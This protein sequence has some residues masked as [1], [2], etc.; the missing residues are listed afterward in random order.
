MFFIFIKY[1]YRKNNM[2]LTYFIKYRQDILHYLNGYINNEYPPKESILSIFKPRKTIDDENKEKVFKKLYDW[3][4]SLISEVSPTDYKGCFVDKFYF[5]KYPICWFRSFCI[6]LFVD[7]SFRSILLQQKL[8]QT[9]Q[10]NKSKKQLLHNFIYKV[11]SFFNNG[12]EKY[13]DHNKYHNLE[14]IHR[15]SGM[16]ELWLF[17]I[18]LLHYYNSELFAVDRIV[19]GLGHVYASKFFEKVFPQL[20]PNVQSLQIT[21]PANKEIIVN[22]PINEYK[23]EPQFITALYYGSFTVN[24]KSTLAFYIKYNNCVYTLSSLIE[25]SK[26]DITTVLKGAHQFGIY[27]CGNRFYYWEG[28]DFRVEDVDLLEHLVLKKSLP[29]K[30]FDYMNFDL[31]NTIRFGMYTKCFFPFNLE[32]VTLLRELE[33][34]ST[35]RL[36]AILS[37]FTN[38]LSFTLV[39]KRNGNQV[40]PLNTFKIWNEIVTENI[41]RK[42]IYYAQMNDSSIIKI[43]EQ[44][45][46][47][48][49]PVKSIDIINEWFKNVPDYIQ[50]TKNILISDFQASF[51]PHQTTLYNIFKLCNRYNGKPLMYLGFG[52]KKQTIKMK[53]TKRVYKVKQNK[54]KQKYVMINRQRVYLKDIKGCYVW[55]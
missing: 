37:Y 49:N 34:A 20:Y 47:I 48:Y 8:Q 15:L 38:K 53:K 35:K 13:K 30:V 54:D 32:E 26:I 40:A 55:V 29:R 51:Y 24:P 17:F 16:E 28:K 1:L 6:I 41:E 46:D 31:H 52:G 19:G 23:L 50:D 18:Y 10:E 4:I 2:D 7:E 9:V 3:Y 12:I 25:T 27:K 36:V 21:L 42:T 43:M 14:F 44:P 33:N 22:L 11:A 5:M 39:E 45:F